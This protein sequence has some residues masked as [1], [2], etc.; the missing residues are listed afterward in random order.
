MSERKTHFA[1][2][3]QRE[4]EMHRCAYSTFLLLLSKLTFG[5][6]VLEHVTQNRPTLRDSAAFRRFEALGKRDAATPVSTDSV[7]LRSDVL[8]GHICNL[9]SKSKLFPPMVA[10]T[11]G[12]DAKLNMLLRI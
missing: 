11:N 6:S 2:N 1:L 9:E 8:I 5:Q 3:E 10:T 12:I 7:A 4:Q